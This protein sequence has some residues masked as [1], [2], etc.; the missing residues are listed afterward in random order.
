MRG[1]GWAQAALRAASG[2]QR[3]LDTQS[4][5]RSTGRD[6][7]LYRPAGWAPPLPRG[8]RE[9]PRLLRTWDSPVTQEP[10]RARDTV[11]T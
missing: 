10:G 5:V 1:V 7:F 2:L 9:G 6:R 11:S 4:Q 8:G 3:P